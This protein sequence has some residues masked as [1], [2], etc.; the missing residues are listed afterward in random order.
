MSY[1]VIRGRVWGSDSAVG[2]A[3]AVERKPVLAA[4][5]VS[6]RLTCD[7]TD[8]VN[9]GGHWKSPPAEAPVGWATVD[10]LGSAQNY[11]AVRLARG[12]E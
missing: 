2:Q 11:T 4:S 9:R 3:H 8:Q 1:Q 7:A 10:W 12:T 5:E 6:F